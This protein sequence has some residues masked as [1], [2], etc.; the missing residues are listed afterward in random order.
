MEDISNRKMMA[1]VKLEKKF[2][3]EEAAVEI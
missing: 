1:E 3:E 2:K